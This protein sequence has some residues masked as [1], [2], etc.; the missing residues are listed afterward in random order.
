MTKQDIHTL[1]R[2][3]LAVKDIL[4]L[5][6]GQVCDIYKSHTFHISDE[7]VYMAELDK[8]RLYE[9]E[10]LDT[11]DIED[12]LSRCFTGKDFLRCTDNNK[13]HAAELFA[14]CSGETPDAAAG[15]IEYEKEDNP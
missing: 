8:T 12:V 15:C 1:L 4:P 11:F 2:K 13:A 7:V 10:K 14:F 6:P 9:T 3:G 5:R